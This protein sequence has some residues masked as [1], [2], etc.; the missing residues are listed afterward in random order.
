MAS[1][2]KSGRSLLMQQPVATP[3]NHHFGYPVHSRESMFQMLSA[4]NPVAL[5]W[6]KGAAFNFP[7]HNPWILPEGAI[8]PI[9]PDM[10][11]LGP[12]ITLLA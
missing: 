1:A 3:I 6:K 8:W 9:L 2:A 11:F 7:P 5:L 10:L 4:F 12:Q